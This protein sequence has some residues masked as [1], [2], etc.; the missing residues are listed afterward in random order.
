[1]FS[2]TAFDNSFISF[3]ISPLNI[4]DLLAILPFLFN[5]LFEGLSI[6][7]LRVIRVIRFFR[8]FRLF[9][10]SRFIKDMRMIVGVRL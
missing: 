5:L 4:I 8:I 1:M 10:L 9:K 2:W 7:G 3:I 6:S